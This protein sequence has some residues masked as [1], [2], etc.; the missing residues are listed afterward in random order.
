MLTPNLLELIMA[1]G[2]SQVKWQKEGN[3]T[4]QYVLQATG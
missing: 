4:I 2:N 1:L 3:L